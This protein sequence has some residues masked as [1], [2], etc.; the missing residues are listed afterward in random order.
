VWTVSD[1]DLG[2]IAPATAALLAT[3]EGRARDRPARADAAGD[4][5]E[6][7]P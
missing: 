4:V 6:A 2:A 7:S 3:C 5:K 1:D